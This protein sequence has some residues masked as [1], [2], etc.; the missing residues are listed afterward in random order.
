MMTDTPARIPHWHI[1]G[2][3]AVG[4]LFA[5][6]ML[7]AGMSVSACPSPSLVGTPRLSLTLE[8]KTGSERFDI[9]LSSTGSIEYL[10]LTTKAQQSK[11]AL[12]AVRDRLTDNTV[13]VV[14]QNG[15]GIHEWLA[16]EYPAVGIVAATTTEGANRPAPQRIRHAGDGTTWLG[17]WRSQDDDVAPQ[18][19]EQWSKLAMNLAFDAEIAQRLWEKLV[20]NCAINPLTALLDCPNGEVRRHEE[21]RIVMQAVVKEVAEVMRVVGRTADDEAL[22][23]KVLAVAERTGAN[24]SSMLQDTRAH[25]STEID[26]INGYVARKAKTLGVSAPVNAWLTTQVKKGNRHSPATL[27]QSLMAARVTDSDL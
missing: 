8:E 5:C 3:G 10:L 20:M 4:G 26:F 23:E 13:I 9:P 12:H 24:I 1:L 14:L 21:T 27:L 6:R 7:A 22:Y 2:L 25:R 18:V 11:A 16:S 15:L 17:P 19:F